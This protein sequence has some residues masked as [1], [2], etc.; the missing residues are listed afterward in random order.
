MKFEA[1]APIHSI[2]PEGEISTCPVCGYR[3]GFHVSFQVAEN[4]TNGH[5]ILICPDCH[6][7]F[8]LGWHVKLGSK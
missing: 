8:R 7:R 5:I 4:H 2:K 1:N 6:H 3:D